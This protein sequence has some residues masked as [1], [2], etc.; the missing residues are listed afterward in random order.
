MKSVSTNTG[1]SLYELMVVVAI[2]AIISTI[3]VPN[4]LGSRLETKLKGAVHNLKADLNA[5]KMMAVR[6]N[7]RVVVKFNANGY[8]IFVDNGSGAHAGN[9]SLDED[10]RRIRDRRLPAGVSI[11][12]AGTDFNGSDFTCFDERGLPDETGSVVLA[13]C[14][15]DQQ[16]ISLNRLGRLKIQ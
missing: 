3:A 16:V 5:A 9:R 10:E 2:I 14:G 4:F 8:R 11:D 13:A 12:L 15:Q 7:A 6:D 1:F